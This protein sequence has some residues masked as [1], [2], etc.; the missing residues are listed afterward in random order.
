MSKGTVEIWTPI[1]PFRKRYGSYILLYRNAECGIYF[2]DPVIESRDY[3]AGYEGIK[4]E[5]L[6]LP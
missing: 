6:T 1:G 2:T 3:Q 5:I 4:G